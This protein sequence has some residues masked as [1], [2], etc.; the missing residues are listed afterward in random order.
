MRIT[1]E[2]AEQ[3]LQEAQK[4]NDGPWIKHSRL[5]AR[6]AKRIAQQAGMDVEKAYVSALLHD[7]GRKTGQMEARHALEGHIRTEKVF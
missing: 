4:L 3:L 5:V 1:A 2:F 7:I 6:L